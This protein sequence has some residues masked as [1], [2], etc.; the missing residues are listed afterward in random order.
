MTFANIFED[1]LRAAGGQPYVSFAG[2]ARLVPIAEKT[3][4]NRE[5]LGR[6]LVASQLVGGKRLVAVR[7]LAAMLAPA[8]PPAPEAQEAQEQEGRKPGRPRKC[9]V[10]K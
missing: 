6:P 10:E 3:F 7:D 4:R 1:L 2:A 8:A 9:G 5:T